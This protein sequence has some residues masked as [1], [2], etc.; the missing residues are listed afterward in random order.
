M[1][2]RDGRISD[3]G[4]DVRKSGQQRFDKL[5]PLLQTSYSSPLC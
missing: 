1:Q 3:E 5:E 2:R 4:S